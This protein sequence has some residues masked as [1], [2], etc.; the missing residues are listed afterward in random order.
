MC[1]CARVFGS[2]MGHRNARFR[3]P[4]C[5]DFLTDMKRCLQDCL[6]APQRLALLGSLARRVR[7]PV[8]HLAHRSPQGLNVHVASAMLYPRKL[9]MSVI[10]TK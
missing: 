6:G 10:G 7:P 3:M 2:V 8:G 9:K 5:S 4:R 1:G